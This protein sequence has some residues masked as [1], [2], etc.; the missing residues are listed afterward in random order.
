VVVGDVEVVV[1][2]AGGEVVV[3]VVAGGGVVEDVPFGAAELDVVP[4]PSWVDDGPD[5]RCEPAS[6]TNRTAAITTITTITTAAIAERPALCG[7]RCRLPRRRLPSAGRNGP[8]HLTLP[9][10]AGAAGGTGTCEASAR[11]SIRRSDGFAVAGVL[12]GGCLGR[13]G[14]T[15][16]AGESEAAMPEASRARRTASAK[17]SRA[18]WSGTAESP[19]GA[20]FPTDLQR[21]SFT[22]TSG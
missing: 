9:S 22:V 6:P 3:E 1:L 5:V 20:G 13:L 15:L 21:P 8:S 16:I 2:A 10:A 7:R 12:G 4:D 11:I 14:D 18:R 19:C 17:A